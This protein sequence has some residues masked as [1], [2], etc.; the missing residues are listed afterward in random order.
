MHQSLYCIA[1]A[2]KKLGQ[3]N[4]LSFLIKSLRRLEG[5]KRL[6]KA[7][8]SRHHQSTLD[9]NI[10][11]SLRN[12]YKEFHDSPIVRNLKMKHYFYKCFWSGLN[13]SYCAKD[14]LCKDLDSALQYLAK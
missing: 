10:L 9:Q 13:C 14:Q 11:K 3:F 7:L 4:Q 5:P 6:L 12:R 2:F 1:L 8:K